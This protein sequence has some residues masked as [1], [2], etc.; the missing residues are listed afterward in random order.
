MFLEGSCHCGRVRF[1]VVTPHPYPFLL[2]C[3]KTAGSG[4]YG[5]NLGADFTTLQIEGQEDIQIYRP[6]IRDAKTGK[7]E[8]SPGEC[9]FYRL[10]G[11]ALWAWD[12][13][14]PT[15]VHPHASAIDTP[16]PVPPEHTH[17]MLS[18]RST[19]VPVFTQPFDKFF[20]GFPDE[21]LTE[22]HHHHGLEQE[23]DG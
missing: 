14:W 4:G 21:S 23:T 9:H 17:R 20:E 2:I 12:P 6:A 10:C 8:I 13:R 7:D 15:L 22:W 1:E 19:W 16:L 5:I 3:L 11:S 18:S